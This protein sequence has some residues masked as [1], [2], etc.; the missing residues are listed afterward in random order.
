MSFSEMESNRSQTWLQIKEQLA[1]A[2]CSS[3][4]EL[5]TGVSIVLAEY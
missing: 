4:G 2:N 5:E 1:K 3:P